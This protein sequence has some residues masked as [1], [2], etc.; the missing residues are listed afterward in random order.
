MASQRVIRQYIIE[1]V[2]VEIPS[3][4]HKCG[5]TIIT[6]PVGRG[7]CLVLQHECDSDGNSAIT[8][9]LCVV[10]IQ[11]VG[12]YVVNRPQ[13]AAFKVEKTSLVLGLSGHH[14]DD[15]YDVI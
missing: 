7:D 3:L 10:F 12:F 1:C 2:I 5:K 14:R 9:E 13:S 8:H 11:Y 4:S 6:E 15:I